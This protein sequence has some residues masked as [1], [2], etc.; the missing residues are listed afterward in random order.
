MPPFKRR[1]STSSPSLA[2]PRSAPPRRPSTLDFM[3]H[4]NGAAAEAQQAHKH[5]D[6]E[7]LHDLGYEQGASPSSPSPPRLLL[8]VLTA[9]VP[10]E[11]KRGWST[12][13]SVGASFSVISVCT[14][15][16]TSFLLG[17]TNGGP[18]VM[19]AST[20]TS[21]ALVALADSCSLCVRRYRLDLRQY[22][23]HV[24]R[25]ALARSDPFPQT[26]PRGR[27]GS[28]PPRWPRS[29][30]PSPRQE[31]RCTGR[32]SSLGPSTARSPPTRLPGSTSSARSPSRRASPS[33]R[34]T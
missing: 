27:A 18:G 16:T 4:K 30:R 5:D 26:D 17:M 13:E 23:D 25:S 31:G 1:T 10:A 2:S 21:A 19:S 20:L 6:A 3:A 12:I 8:L 33:V 24:R 22:H 11:L 32:H 29:C 9:S 14:G 7:R 34:P 28:S 15:I